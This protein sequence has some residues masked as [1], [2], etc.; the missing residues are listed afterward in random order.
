MF[1][2]MK[3]IAFI[4][5]LALSVCLFCQQLFAQSKKENYQTFRASIVAGANAAQIDG[6]DLAG[7]NK[8]GI[9]A[10][11]EV[12]VR[13]HRLFESSVG[14]YYS[15]KGSASELSAGG[16]DLLA[17]F[18]LN[19]VQIP[20]MVTYDDDGLQFGAG[21][22]YS[23]LINSKII[24]LGELDEARSDS[25]S[26]NDFSFVAKG[27]YFIKD[28]IGF[29]LGFERSLGNILKSDVEREV[30]RLIFFTASYRI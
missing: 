22:S 23:R 1:V 28:R 11:A 20:L 19:Y 3:Q 25:Y 9:R 15:Q 18:T 4:I 6:D 26:K 10:G 5:L 27:G 30:N 29:H 2:M 14:M 17:R 16:T 7:F 8:L 24:I 13:W 21:F 12:G